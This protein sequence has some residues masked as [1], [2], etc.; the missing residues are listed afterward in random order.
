[1]DTLRVLLVG[2]P[3]DGGSAAAAVACCVV[4]AAQATYGRSGCTQRPALH[5][6][7]TAEACVL[8]IKQLAD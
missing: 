4:I 1:M 5:R 3:V 8:S 6:L 2:T 7:T